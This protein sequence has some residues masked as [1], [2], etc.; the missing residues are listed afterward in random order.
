ML[1]VWAGPSLTAPLIGFLLQA[2]M[3]EDGGHS[4][5]DEDDEAGGDDHDGLL[6]RPLPSPSTRRIV[7]SAMSPTCS[8]HSLAQNSHPSK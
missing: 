2:E 8:H 6:V 3:S 7:F 4:D 5:E 1:S